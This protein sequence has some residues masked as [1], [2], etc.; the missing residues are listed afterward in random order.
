MPER[1]RYLAQDVTNLN[2]LKNV[3]KE[4]LCLFLISM[5]HQHSYLAGGDGFETQFYSY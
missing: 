4:E 2:I 5:Q 1:I 3:K